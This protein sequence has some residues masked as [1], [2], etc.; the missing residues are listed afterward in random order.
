MA[1]QIIHIFE[2]NGFTVW[3]GKW[4]SPIDWQHFQTPRGIAQL[5]AAMTYAD[6]KSFFNLYAKTPILFNKMPHERNDFIH[7]YQ[8]SQSLFMQVLKNNFDTLS[9][10]EPDNAILFLKEQIKI[11]SMK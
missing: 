1:E 5:L 9:E 10:L 7:L 6:A 2:K 4:N 3:G 11:L 8:S